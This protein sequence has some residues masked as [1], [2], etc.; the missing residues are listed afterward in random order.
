MFVIRAE[1]GAAC[2]TTTLR[3]DR[4]AA[5]GAYVHGYGAP[6]TPTRHRAIEGAAP[7]AVGLVGTWATARPTSALLDL[8][9]RRA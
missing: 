8:V 7:S 3:A 5:H 2:P 1:G 9:G 6:V 4:N